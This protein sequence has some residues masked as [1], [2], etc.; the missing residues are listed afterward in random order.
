VASIDTLAALRRLYPAAKGRAIDE[1]LSQLDPHCQNFIASSPFVMVASVGPT[2]NMDTSPRGGAAG[3]VK[4]PDAHM[5]LIG[6]APCNSR[7]DTLENRHPRA[8]RAA[9]PYPGCGRTLRI[10][11][12]A[13]LSDDGADERR[14]PKLVVRVTVTEAYVHCAKALTRSA[15]WDAS[16][17]VERTCL[18]PMSR[19]IADQTRSEVPLETNDDMLARYANDL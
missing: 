16:R 1:Q 19:M 6:D 13:V 10:N 5:L 4:T 11:G 9:V 3:F 18:P 12:G 7:L 15:L 8:P 17:Q 2:G 14:R